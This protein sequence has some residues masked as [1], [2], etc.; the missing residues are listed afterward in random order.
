MAILLA[1]QACSWLYRKA[2][3]YCNRTM[4]IPSL[5]LLLSLPLSALTGC[6]DAA[7]RHPLVQG[8][9][10]EK[11][12]GKKNTRGKKGSGSAIRVVQRWTM[13]AALKEISGHAV[14]DADRFA[15]IQDED[16]R[17][18]IYSRSGG[19]VESEIDFAGAGDY[20]DI[21]LVGST[22]YV[23]RS[24]GQLYRVADYRG[25][26]PTVR[27]YETG[28][29]AKQE[30]EGLTHDAAHNRLLLSVKSKEGGGADYKGIYAFNLSTHR[31]APAPVYRL[32]LSD[33]LL[34]GSKEPMPSALA[35]HPTTG[36]VYIVDG[37]GKRILIMGGNG[38][39]KSVHDVSSVLPQPEGIAIGADGRIYVSS[40]GGKGDGII[41]EAALK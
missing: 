29:T 18:F 30:I 4:R 32:A 31:L 8:G 38:A 35:V 22:A 2:N 21:A 14:V 9:G 17:I 28:L 16:G 24:D 40:E 10:K 23:V 15:C 19:R 11:G 39:L 36:D 12:K 7:A 3:K 13:P 33:P 20:E 5:L 26:K 1:A 37:P 25:G 27:T 34:N 6:D 41:V